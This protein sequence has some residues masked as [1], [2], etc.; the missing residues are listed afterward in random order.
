MK[1]PFGYSPYKDAKNP[2]AQVQNNLRTT[3]RD[4]IDKMDGEE[5]EAFCRE[6]DQFFLETALEKAKKVRMKFFSETNILGW[7]AN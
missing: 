4:W 1:T 5:F 7:M 6:F 3:M 2:N